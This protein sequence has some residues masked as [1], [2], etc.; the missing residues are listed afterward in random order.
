MKKM[1]IV[2][3]NPQNLYMLQILLETNGYEVVQASN[4]RE[5]LKLASKT[6]PDMIISDILMPVMD[7]FS[8]CHAW[9]R[10]ERLRTLPFIFY[11]ATYTDPKDEAF[12]LSLGAERFIVKPV[13]PDDFLNVLQEIIQV[14]E[15]R[16]N[17]VPQVMAK[18]EEEYYKEY[19]ETLIRKLEDKMIQLERA[20][21]RLAS[22]YQASC[23]LATI[24]LSTD[25]IHRVIHA[26]VETAGY[27]RVNYY[28]FDSE[29]N[30]LFLLDG[31]GFSDEILA[32][33]KEKGVYILD[34]D[35]GLV[36]LAA[37]RRQIINVRDTTKD[38]DWIT[39]DPLINSALFVPVIY[40]KT[41]LGVFALYST[42]K[43]SFA[44]EDERNVAALANSLAVSIEN[45]KA[46]EEILQ[47]NVQLEQ[48]IAERTAQLD[49]SNKELEAFAYSV[50]HDL[51]APL[52]VIVG[53]TRILHEDYCNILDDEGNRLLNNIINNTSRMDN[54]ITDMLALSKVSRSE[55][56]LTRIGMSALVNTVYNETVSPEEQE[57]CVLIVDPLTDVYGDSTLMCQVWSNLLSNAI[58]Y[59][60]P[61]EKCIINIKSRVEGNMTIY[62]I[63]D[64]GVGFNPKDAHRLFGLFQRL[65]DSDKFDGTGIGL[66]IVKRIIERHGGQVWAE[67][68]LDEG[69]IFSFSIPM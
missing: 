18:R 19:S 47:L 41:L 50:S 56:R 63:Q 55:L 12:A 29:Q 37:R 57:R 2:D 38:L 15:T 65:H 31:V 3:D 8:L 17:I 66:A 9:K 16:E 49:T 23:D 68:A 30:K 64:N 60:T 13:S 27:Q 25:L 42:E 40:E 33:F 67:G 20:N 11:T 7:G 62:S 24:K 14:D 10:D 53:F 52:R 58:K 59:T 51:R 61:R 45:R 43:N 4:G 36:G 46:K 28:H 39:V 69:A 54:L 35:Q 32:K 34:D 1:L 6:P 22:L 44:E 48:R 21:K 26:I 5:A